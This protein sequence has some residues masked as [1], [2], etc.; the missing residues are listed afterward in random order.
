MK[1]KLKSLFFPIV[2]IGL[3]SCIYITDEESS[4][5]ADWDRDGFNIDEDCDDGNDMIFPQSPYEVYGDGLD[6]DCDG[7]DDPVCAWR[8]EWV[9][10]CDTALCTSEDITLLQDWFAAGAIPKNFPDEW[11][12]T[13]DCSTGLGM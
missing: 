7:Y 1:L 4:L 11:I 6:W 5:L 3:V 9:E 12:L 10:F 13:E 2:L 8:L